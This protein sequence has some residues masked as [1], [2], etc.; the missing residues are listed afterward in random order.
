MQSTSIFKTNGQQMRTNRK[1]LGLL[2]VLV[3][4]FSSCNKAH[5]TDNPEA[6]FQ[7]IIDEAT[8]IENYLYG[9]SMHVEAPTKNISWSGA[10]GF[11]DKDTFPILTNNH[12]FLISSITKTYVAASIL[13]LH[14]DG[15]LSIDDPIGNYL[16]ETYK[17]QL[18][19]GGYDPMDITFRH[20]ATHTSGLFDYGTDGDYIKLVIDDPQHIWTRDEQLARAM[21]KGK[22]YGQPGKVYQYSDTGYILMGAII[23][24]L[25]GKD[26]G[27]A[28]RSLLNF[29]GLGLQATWWN[30]SEQRPLSITD[31]V[32]QHFANQDTYNYNST[33]DTHGGGGLA[34]T[35]RDVAVFYQLLFSNKVFKHPATLKLLLEK[36]PLPDDYVYKHLK[37]NRNSLANPNTDYRFGFK[38]IKIFGTEAYT[39]GGIL[40]SRVI[41]VPK[42][43]VAVAMNCTNNSAD[44]ILKRVVL[45]AGEEE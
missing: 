28:V 32:H 12:G 36:A 21:E 45:R 8:A 30:H 33:N 20:C 43:D 31:M 34:A 39:H 6:D 22:P 37:N 10:S 3:M 11:A 9:I 41:Y 1:Y 42:Y 44:F 13:R 24:D 2:A 17:Q 5:Y 38:A 16:S 18:I 27:P 35:A 14:E 23:E 25:T 4:L 7:S 26:L 15:L 40:G 19:K 29:E